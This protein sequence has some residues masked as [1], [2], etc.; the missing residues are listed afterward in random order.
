MNKNYAYPLDL[1]WSTDEISSVLHFLNQVE[2]AYESKV[3]ADKVLAAY[4]AFKQVVPSKAEE[5]RI[6]KTFEAVSGYS[7]YKVVQAAKAQQK[8]WI[9]L[10]N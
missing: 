6:D 4:Q 1:S 2:L 9:A 3:A 8:G 7:T 5:K 10:G